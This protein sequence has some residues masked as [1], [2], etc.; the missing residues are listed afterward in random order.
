MQERMISANQYDGQSRPDSDLKLPAASGKP[1]DKFQRFEDEE[2]SDDRSGGPREE[3]KRQGKHPR[4]NPKEQ[5]R[6]S[7]GF[8]KQD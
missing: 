4:L 7:G 5:M 2:Q 3:S 6:S 1:N 8:V